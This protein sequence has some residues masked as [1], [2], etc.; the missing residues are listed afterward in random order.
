[1]DQGS[2]ILPRSVLM[3]F[4]DNSKV[5]EAYRALLTGSAIAIRDWLS[6]NVTN[7]QI[8]AEV[9]AVLK[10]ESQLALVKNF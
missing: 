5:T 9:D 1:M 2:L 4:E 3:D 8:E 10:F 7:A 6:S